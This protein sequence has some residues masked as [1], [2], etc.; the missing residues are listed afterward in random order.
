M[1]RFV[2]SVL[3]GCLAVACG[4]Q[5]DPSGTKLDQNIPSCA[6]APPPCR[7]ASSP[8]VDDG[9]T[10]QPSSD[11]VGPTFRFNV[12][13]PPDGAVAAGTEGV[14]FVTVTLMA[15]CGDV[16]IT[17]MDF[18]IRAD[19][20]TF[21]CTNA[22][23]VDQNDWNFQNPSFMGGDV[24]ILQPTGFQVAQAYDGTPE[25]RA[26]FIGPFVLQ[27]DT[28]ATFEFRADIAPHDIVPGSLIGHQFIGLFEIVG[29]DFDTSMP[30]DPTQNLW[31]GWQTVIAP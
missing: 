10:D 30:I 16:T 19:A 14:P 2:L 27:Q 12:I 7:I 13:G 4:G 25:I 23:G 17:E 1:T 29:L 9:G 31:G 11:C 15:S 5:V 22:C 6:D 24:N 28:E 26:S 18:A 20:P 8:P 21:F 3:T